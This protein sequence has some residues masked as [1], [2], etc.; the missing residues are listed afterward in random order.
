MTLRSASRAALLA[1]ALLAATVSCSRK[2]AAA[3]PPAA[4]PVSVRLAVAAS[5]DAP[6]VVTAFGTTV[7]RISV[8]V[9][10]Q[11]S[12]TLLRK[13]VA[14]GAAVTN[15]QPLFQIDATDYA[16]R[17][18]QA[19]AL[20]AADAAGLDLSRLTAQRTAPLLE[21]NLV[22]QADF[23]AL[24]ARVA[25]ATA[26]LRADEAVLDQ[27][28]LSLARC[29]VTATVD[30]VCSKIYVDEGNLVG[31]GQTRLVN[32]RNLD[33]L[34][35]EFAVPEN[36]LSLLRAA[37]AQPPVPL[38]IVPRGE[39]NVYA[40]TLVS[41]DNA[42]NPLTGTILLRGQVPNPDRRLWSHQFVDVRVRAGVERGAVLVPE[43]AVQFGKMGAYLY[44]VNAAGEAE[45]RTVET[46]VR[47]NDQIQIVR[48][49]AAGEKVVVLGQLL[50]HPGAKVMDLADMPPP[51]GPPPASPPAAER[52]EKPE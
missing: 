6:V 3:G 28:R 32:I 5:R 11:V 40:G 44:A 33:P 26:Q 20:V 38:E 31:A 36:R 12:G 48:G 8:D 51:G 14:D 18:R 23:D 41:I 19:E 46:G 52:T 2:P 42:V 45:P 21:K 43:G 30:G 15:G 27:A 34:L 9:V 1:G 25:A 13:L 50:L 4:P 37:L 16:L 17:V 35:V 47:W 10:P 49:A 39:T 29:T 7:D 22:A 24:T